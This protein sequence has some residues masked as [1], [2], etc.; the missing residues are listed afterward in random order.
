[1]YSSTRNENTSFY[2]LI[3]SIYLVLRPFLVLENVLNYLNNT[4]NYFMALCM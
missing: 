4:K 2:K 3:F 1:M